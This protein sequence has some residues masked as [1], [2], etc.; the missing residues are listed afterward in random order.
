MTQ[1]INRPAQIYN[2]TFIQTGIGNRTVQFVPNRTEKKIGFAT[3]AYSYSMTPEMRA[4]TAER[5]QLSM[6]LLRGIPNEGI[7]KMIDSMNK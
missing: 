2:A 4:Y 5:I 1:Y 7:K 3:A 6:R